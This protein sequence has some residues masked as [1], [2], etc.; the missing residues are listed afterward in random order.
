[1]GSN[2]RSQERQPLRSQVGGQADFTYSMNPD[3]IT[4]VDLD[5]G[6]RSVTNDIRNVLRKIEYYHQG[7]I[8]GLKIVY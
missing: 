3:V 6:G 8:K 4:I 1:M 2:I 7:S 5:R